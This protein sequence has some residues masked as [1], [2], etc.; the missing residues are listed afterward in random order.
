MPGNYWKKFAHA[1]HMENN[2]FETRRGKAGYPGFAMLWDD[3]S[4]MALTV[5]YGTPDVRMTRPSA[6]AICN[7][8]VT[9]KG[10]C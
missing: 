9:I 7:I 5:W 3:T 4:I 6:R 8:I 10:K 2:W 1:N